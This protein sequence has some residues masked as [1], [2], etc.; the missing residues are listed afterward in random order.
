MMKKLMA[1]PFVDAAAP[2]AAN[3]TQANGINYTYLQLDYVNITQVGNAGIMGPV[4]DKRTAIG[5]VGYDHGVSSHGDGK[6][7][8]QFGLVYSL[9][10]SGHHMV[11]SRQQR[12]WSMSVLAPAS[13]S[14]LSG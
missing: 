4:T 5:Y 12:T 10:L 7:F 9:T 6:F 11:A 2:M 3:A 8:G 14:R 1:Q 13:D